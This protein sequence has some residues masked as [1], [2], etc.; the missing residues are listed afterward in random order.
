MKIR[1]MALVLLTA[2]GVLVACHGT[3]NYVPQGG[4]NLSDS[5]LSLDGD[6][7]PDLPISQ[8]CAHIPFSKV[9]GEYV[10]MTAFGNLSSSSFTGQGAWFI[11]DYKP[12]GPAPSKTPKPGKIAAWL[13]YGSY[14]LKTSKQT[15]CAFFFAS[16]SG[17]PIISTMSG[18]SYN[19]ESFAQVVVKLK[20]WHYAKQTGFGLLSA[21]ITLSSATSGKG[22][23]ILTTETGQPYDTADITLVGRTIVKI[24]TSTE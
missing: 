22:S 20:H 4:T 13:Y 18:K 14:S 10:V 7:L 15:G 21:M 19:A 2:L 5:T 1:S 12:G 9:P 8:L 17:K 16:K 11:E 6:R 23:A 3:S 24:T